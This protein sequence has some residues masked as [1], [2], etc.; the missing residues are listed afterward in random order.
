[1]KNLTVPFVAFFIVIGCFF[2]GEY[3]FV[4]NTKQENIKLTVT[5]NPI[6]RCS[7]NKNS[8]CRNIII[9]DKG[10]YVAEDSI[11][12]WH[13]RSTDILAMMQPGASCVVDTTGW[14]WGLT[15]SYPNIIKAEC[16][17]A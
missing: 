2:L 15:S 14:R 1:M 7:G 11:M 3:A 17:N 10:A 6:Q 12:F 5:A 4:I 16:D 9:T 13:F 8:E